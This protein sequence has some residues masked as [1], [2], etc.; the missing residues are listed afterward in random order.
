[1]LYLRLIEAGRGGVR[2]GGEGV[3]VWE[4]EEAGGGRRG[5]KR[6][7]SSRGTFVVLAEAWAWRL[8]EK[9]GDGAVL[10]RPHWAKWQRESSAVPRGPFDGM[11]SYKPPGHVRRCLRG[12]KMGNRR[13]W[14]AHKNS[15]TTHR[16]EQQWKWASSAVLWKSCEKTHRR[17]CAAATT[18]PQSCSRF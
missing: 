10:S 2:R 15:R 9:R 4:K 14:A 8:G 3:G 12:S 5:A 17:P 16:K 18:Q 7:A 6:A 1:M 13:A 11:R